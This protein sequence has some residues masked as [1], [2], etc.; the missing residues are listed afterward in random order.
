MAR[1]SR[2]AKALLAMVVRSM[3]KSSAGHLA[4]P[5][6]GDIAESQPNAVRRS[7]IDPVEVAIEGVEGFRGDPRAGARIGWIAE[8]RCPCHQL[9]RIVMRSVA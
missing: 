4:R 1:L 3:A 8:A 2:A 7:G 5:V 6:A 9:A